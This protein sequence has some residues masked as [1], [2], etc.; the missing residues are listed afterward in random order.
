MGSGQEHMQSGF[1][2]QRDDL[3]PVQDKTD[4]TRFYHATQNDVQFKIYK[5]FFL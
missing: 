2:G 3:H 1:T 5:L 4:S